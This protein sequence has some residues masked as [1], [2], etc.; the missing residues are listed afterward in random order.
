MATSMP[1]NT[2]GTIKDHDDIY[3]DLSQRVREWVYGI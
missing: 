3:K 1:Y 2:V